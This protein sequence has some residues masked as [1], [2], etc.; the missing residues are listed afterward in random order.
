MLY[1][2]FKKTK[3]RNFKRR[4]DRGFTLIELS[5]VI[6]IIGLIVA[7]V[8]GGQTLVKQAKIRTLITEYNEMKLA[9]NAFKLEYDAIPGDINN[10]VAY[11]IGVAGHEG[12]GDK[13]I[14]TRLN[15]ALYAWEHL[16]NAELLSG[17]Y[18]GLDNGSPDYV[19]GVNVPGSSFGSV[20]MKFIGYIGRNANCQSTGALPLFGEVDN[21]NILMF[22]RASGA[23]GCPAL[24]F[25]SAKDAHGIDVKMDDG[26]PDSGNMY[27]MNQGN[28]NNNL[29][30]D[31][32]V[33]GTGGADYVLNAAG[34]GCRIWFNL[35]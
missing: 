33:Q 29:C 20:V 10:A 25:L 16:V 12:N 35:D 15:E 11:G 14:H 21:R 22:G 1:D 19:I 24:P 27:S 3:I 23:A 9:M 17:S 28:A 2:C 34:E 4:S 18:T 8:V 30:V 6:V 5:I 26:L 31:L 13:A 7:G 32:N